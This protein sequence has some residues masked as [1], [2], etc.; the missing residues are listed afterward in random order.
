M[1]QKI[2]QTSIKTFVS[3][4]SC[5]VEQ[6]TG[7]ILSNIPGIWQNAHTIYTIQVTIISTEQNSVSQSKYSCTKLQSMG[8]IIYLIES[9]SPS[10]HKLRFWKNFGW[11]QDT[12]RI[13]FMIISYYLSKQVG[14]ISVFT[15]IQLLYLIAL[16]Q[17]QSTKNIRF[18]LKFIFIV[19][20]SPK[21][22]F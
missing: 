3:Q 1:R 17:L 11:F 9:T 4:E 13:L 20:L 2:F 10:R 15:N 12:I 6:S 18:L 21:S 19:N 5:S 8:S 16:Y 7:Q 22:F 14:N